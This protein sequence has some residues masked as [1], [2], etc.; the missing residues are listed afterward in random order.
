MWRGLVDLKPLV[1]HRHKFADA[2]AAME[3]AAQGGEGHIK[4]V[5]TF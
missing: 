5:L 3:A 2:Q 4:G 1:S